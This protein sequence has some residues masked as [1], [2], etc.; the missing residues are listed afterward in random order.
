MPMIGKI[1]RM[2]YRDRLTISEISRRTSLSRM[3]IRKWL[4]EPEPDPKYERSDRPS[5]LSAYKDAIVAAL[6]VDAR[7][8]HRDRRT[9]KRL[10][11]E[12]QAQGYPGGYTQFSQFIAQWRKEAGT[13]PLRAFSTGS[14]STSLSPSE[15]L[16]AGVGSMV[17]ESGAPP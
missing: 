16:S 8:P 4:N 17:T 10:Y 7:R 2:F 3:T 12:F 11:Q 5:K 13:A 15:A 9:A 6:Q 1:R 14:S